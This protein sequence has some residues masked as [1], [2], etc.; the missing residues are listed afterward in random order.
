MQDKTILTIAIFAIF[1]MIS[2][3]A[4]TLSKCGTESFVYGNFAFFAA[5]SGRCDE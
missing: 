2:T 4:F 1:I 5:A 3:T